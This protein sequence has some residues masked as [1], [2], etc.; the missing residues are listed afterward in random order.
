MRY[1]STRAEERAREETYRIYLT[2]ALKII[3]GLEIR[4]AEFLEPQTQETRT[5]EEIVSNIN[6]KLKK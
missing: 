6:N 5:E 2:D 3:G 1:V 4:Y